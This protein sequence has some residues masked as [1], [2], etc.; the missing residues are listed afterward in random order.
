MIGSDEEEERQR[1]ERERARL[2][3]LDR[4]HGTPPRKTASGFKDL[5]SNRR[6]GRIVQLP[7][8]LHPRV[9]AMID[10]IMLRD[11]HPSVVVLFEEML[12]AYLEK[13]GDLD[14]TLVPSDEELVKRIEH[15][16]DERDGE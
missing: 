8:R 9:K 13:H 6:T 16:R 11:R 2:S 5:R 15:E 1:Q 12:D 3:L 7:L 10:A 14:P 4:L